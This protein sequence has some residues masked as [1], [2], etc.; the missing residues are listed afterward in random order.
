M[1]RQRSPRHA[2]GEFVVP[3]LRAAN[4]KDGQLQLDDVLQM[5]FT[6][7]EQRKYRLLPGDVLVTEGCGSLAQLG[8]SCAWQGDMPGPVCFQNTLL[9]L[10]A[11]PDI[12]L[13]EFVEV[14]ARH[15]HA[16]GV[17][18]EIAAGTNIYHIGSQRA[19]N[20][21]LGVP[22]LAEQRRIVD[23]SRAINA[24]EARALEV[25]AGS[26]L[27]GEAVVDEWFGQADC[28]AVPLGVIAGG[29]IQIG[30]FGSQLHASDYVEVG[31]PSVMPKDMVDG[32][33]DETTVARVTP[34]KAAQLV[35]HQLWPGDILL[36]RRG[37]LRKRALVTA[38][39][40]GWLC[41]TGTVRVR[42]LPDHDP[43]VVYRAL[44]TSAVNRWL[45]DH[46]VGATMPNLNTQL[47]SEIPVRVPAHSGRVADVLV[48][49]EDTALQAQ[50]EARAASTLRREIVSLLLSGS[51]RIPAAYDALLEAS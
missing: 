50:Q 16:T 19:E 27:A 21:S 4:V 6:P 1:G 34:E 9:R 39:Q 36:P 22:P 48:A 37:D 40:A 46:A 41:G 29:G 51:L 7:T 49:L 11:K 18:A 8:A 2:H 32:R 3:Y 12:A 14:W 28:P 13:P 44:C 17:W 23:V 35:R 30:P 43:R 24:L 25:A 31:V 47:V 15:A 20:L 45:A 5:N 26:L 33:I 42:L 38:E 10:R